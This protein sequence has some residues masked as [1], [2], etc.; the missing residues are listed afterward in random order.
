MK[1]DPENFITV[2]DELRTRISDN[3]LN[4]F[5]TDKSFMLHIILKSLPVLEYESIVKSME[6]DLGIRVDIGP[7]Y[8]VLSRIN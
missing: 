7:V 1:K 2:L 6:R 4:K 8:P 5:I 3:P